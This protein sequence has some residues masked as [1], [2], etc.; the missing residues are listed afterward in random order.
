MCG[1]CAS[2]ERARHVRCACGPGR[3][4]RAR[5]LAVCV[6]AARA[7]G[8]ARR[9]LL[10][11]CWPGRLPVTVDS[12]KPHRSLLSPSPLPNL[13][14]PLLPWQLSPSLSLSQSLDL[15]LSLTLFLSRSFSLSLSLSQSSALFSSLLLSVHKHSSCISFYT[16]LAELR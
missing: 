14:I 6:R 13:V 1:L 4:V 10:L 3:S 8:R 2:R 12:H 9:A 15:S 11:I 16:I 7:V 5:R